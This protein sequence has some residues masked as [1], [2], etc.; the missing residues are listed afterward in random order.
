MHNHCQAATWPNNVTTFNKRKQVLG[1]MTMRKKKLYD[2]FCSSTESCAESDKLPEVTLEAG[3]AGLK[4]RSLGV[5][6][7]RS[8]YQTL[9]THHKQNTPQ[10]PKLLFSSLNSV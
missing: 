10:S 8:V 2:F 7:E 5:E 4:K 1:S 3:S 9:V 6:L